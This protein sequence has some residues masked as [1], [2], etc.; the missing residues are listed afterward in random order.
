MMAWSRYLPFGGGGHTL[1]GGGQGQ[2]GGGAAGQQQG[3]QGH[4]AGAP[5]GLAA[6]GTYLEWLWG[7]LTRLLWAPLRG[8]GLAWHAPPPPTPL[9]EADPSCMHRPPPTPP[10][11]PI[12]SPH[13]Y[14]RPWVVGSGKTAMDCMIKL[15]ALGESVTS[16][17]RCIA[18]RGTWFGVREVLAGPT[19]GQH[20]VHML[21]M[22]DGSNGTEVLREMASRGFLHSAVPDPSS[23]QVAGVPPAIQCSQPPAIQCSACMVGLWCL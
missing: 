2:D 20:L 21:D 10:K 23:F 12:A 14:I 6:L 8:L 15:A 18:G 19:G 1:Q 11:S 5:L 9:P 16:R 22:F 7:W 13:S 17:V 4:G 3:Q